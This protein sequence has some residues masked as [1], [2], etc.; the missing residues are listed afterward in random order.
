MF[1]PLSAA[2]GPALTTLTRNWWA[3]VLRGVLAVIFGILALIFPGHVLVA[4]VLIFGVYAILD[5]I[6]NI[7]SVVVSAAARTHWL[8]LLFEGVVSIIAGIIAFFFTGLT[9]LALLYLIAAWA[10]ITGIAEIV[11][12]IRL[13]SVINNEWLLI[14]GGILSIGF[15]I[16]IAIFTGPAALAIV[17][18]IGIYAILFGAAL[19]GLGFRLRAMRSP[20]ATS[21]ASAN[22]PPML[23]A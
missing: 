13:R 14:I 2:P 12:A 20:Q 22:M 23:P 17:W 21:P 16:I 3:V 7:V 19:I 5:G 8:S 11:S 10:I 15:G 6:F 4:L 1:S 9:A 18:V